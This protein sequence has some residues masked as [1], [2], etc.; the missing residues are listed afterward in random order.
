VAVMHGI[1]SSGPVVW[2]EPLPTFQI[3]TEVGGG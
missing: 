1:I 2:A 3:M